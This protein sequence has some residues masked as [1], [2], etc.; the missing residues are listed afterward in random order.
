MF[1]ITFKLIMFNIH[2][3]LVASSRWEN[4]L[5]AKI[6]P[7]PRAPPATEAPVRNFLAAPEKKHGKSHGKM[8]IVNPGFNDGVWLGSIHVNSIQR[9]AH[10]LAPCVCIGDR[11]TF[12][13][14][15]LSARDSKTTSK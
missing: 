4:P 3:F 12:P 8:V 6:A 11:L 14:A 9:V 15:G 2:I 1:T 10:H 5:R 13:N 7:M